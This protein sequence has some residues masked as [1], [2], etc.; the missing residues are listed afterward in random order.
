MT[1][2]KQDQDTQSLDHIDVFADDAKVKKGDIFKNRK[3]TYAVGRRKNAISTL[4][5][6]HEG[7]GRIFVNDK[8]YRQYFPMLDYQKTLTQALDVI[9]QRADFDVS[10]KTSGG[11]LRGQVD[12]IKLAMARALAIYNPDFRS[13]FKKV[14]LFTRDARV[15]ERKKPGLKRARRAPQWKKR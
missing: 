2:E 12:S 1:E 6:Y 8:E 9:K 5:L 13:A 3:Y 4:R 15:K 7:K 14:S 11:G 10:V